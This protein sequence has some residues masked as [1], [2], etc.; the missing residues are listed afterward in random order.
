MEGSGMV[1]DLLQSDDWMC[2]LDLK[3]AYHSVAIAKEHCKYLCFL[4]NGRIYEF[5]CPPFGFCSA[6]RIFTKLL[7]PAMAHL[8]SWGVRL[9]IYLD[10]ILLMHQ[11]KEFL[12]QQVKMTVHLIESLR[13]TINLEKSRLRLTQ[14]IQFLG[15]ILDS[16]QMKLFLPEEKILG[17]S[18]MCQSLL[19]QTKV[20]IRQMSQL[21]GRM[22]AA[23]PAVLSAP[24]RYHQLQHLKIRSFRRFESFDAL[25]TLDQGAIQDLRWWKDHLATTNGKDITQPPPDLVIDTDASLTG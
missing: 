6:P 1:K 18:Q 17:I 16:T 12:L 11:S 21:L 8:R 13:F 25:V 10:D 2:S 20:S 19:D 7:R 4:W 3:N 5:T 22:V 24:L 14:Q 9:I 15:F 23:S